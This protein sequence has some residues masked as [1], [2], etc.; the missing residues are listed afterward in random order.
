MDFDARLLELA[1]LEQQVKERNEVAQQMRDYFFNLFVKPYDDEIAANIAE[2]EAQRDQFDLDTL[3]YVAETGDK[4]PHS[5]ITYRVMP[6][7]V[8]DKAVVLK[9]AEDYGAAHLIRVKR[10]LDVRAFEKDWKAGR[11]EWASVEK[12]EEPEIALAKLG[13]LLIEAEFNTAHES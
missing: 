5:K 2:L 1:R 12:V 8:Y 7:L 9:L 4:T 11:A 6:R 10:E 3:A 13:D